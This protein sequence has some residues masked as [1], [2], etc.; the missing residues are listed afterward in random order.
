[1]EQLL[2]QFPAA[3]TRALADSVAE[4]PLRN[5]LLSEAEMVRMHRRRFLAHLYG[6]RDFAPVFVHDGALSEQGQTIV[7]ALEGVGVHGLDPTDYLNDALM[8]ALDVQRQ[9]THARRALPPISSVSE[10]E[11]EAIAALVEPLTEN[12]GDAAAYAIEQALSAETA[13][14]SPTPALWRIHRERVSLERVGRGNDALIEVLVADGVLAYAFDQ[15]NFNTSWV[16]EDLDEDERHELIAERTR[17][18]FEAFA[19]APNAVA[20]QSVFDALQPHYPQY[21]PLL[22]ERARYAEIVAAGG[23]EEITPRSVRRGSSGSTVTALQNR[24]AAEGYYDGPIDGEAGEAFIESIRAYQTTHQM[25]VTGQSSAG[26]WN[27][28]NVPA[29]DRL[30]QIDLTLQ[31]WRESA[32]GPDDYYVFVNIP[33]FHAE[34]WNGGERDMRFRIVVGNSEQVCDP[35]TGRL[36]YANATPIQSVPMTYVVLNPTWNVP[37]RIV[38]EELLPSLARDPDYFADRGFERHTTSGGIDIVRQLPGEHNPLG[39]VK[40]IFPN[41]HNTYMHDTSRPQYFNYTVRAF[42]HGCMR[43]QEPLELLEYILTQDGQ[44]DETQIE[45]TFRH[46]REEGVSL[47]TPIPVHMEYYVVRADDDGR[48]NFLA[49]IY[50]LDRDRLNPPSSASLRCTPPAPEPRMVLAEGADGDTVMLQDADGNRYTA[51]QWE[52]IR[53]GGTLEQN[54]DGSFQDPP[55]DPPPV[56]EVLGGPVPVDDA[57]AMPDDVAGDLG[58]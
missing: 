28:I 21:A 17:Q 11:R 54:P 23:W 57:T 58:P 42:S 32:I 7:S 14:L 55:V 31:R 22:A 34:V 45:R 15:K 25:D 26:F 50:R 12:P 33:D 30:A 36:R 56:V 38:E 13:E 4:V 53:E 8:A 6:E 5:V 43:V 35:R 1:M 47:N 3:Y 9:I 18:T 39:R 52:Y 24:L 41:S 19:D 40:F 16:D 49:D 46:G 29:E 48:A 37:S 20:T 44:W 51:A 10:E 2:E 27:S